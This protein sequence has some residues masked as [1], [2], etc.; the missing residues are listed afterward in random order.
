MAIDGN[1][2]LYHYL[3]KQLRE[4]D[5]A[6]FEKLVVRF[7]T[8]LG[9]WF[10]PK[11]YARL[12][13]L[14]PHVVRDSSCRP[15][16]TGDRDEWGAPDPEGYCRDDNSLVKG[17]PR[18][19]LIRSEG[20]VLYHRKRV[21]NGFVASHVWRSAETGD[22]ASKEGWTNT[23]IPN[24]V[25]LPTQLAKLTD[26]EGSFT[27][28]FLQALSYKLYRNAEVPTA[29]RPVVE[30][31][32]HQLTQ[33]E[34]VH[35]LPRTEDLNFFQETDRFIERRVA[36]IRRTRNGLATLAALELA[37]LRPSRYAKGLARKR[38]ETTDLLCRRLSLYLEAVAT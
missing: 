23:F 5:G 7:I 12:P 2:I 22:H 6:L 36:I 18:A 34:G 26:R 11:L 37:L 19:L 10:S 32:W 8:S 28:G 3:Q 31:A 24:L 35:D 25:W 20:N 1:H 21:G 29:L 9:V 33:P 4:N 27:Q 14:V 16:H 38:R 13:I 17:L 15:R 30:A